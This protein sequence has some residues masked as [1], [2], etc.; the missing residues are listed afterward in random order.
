MPPSELEELVDAE[1]RLDQRLAEA[2]RVAAAA[3]DAAHRRV[4]EAATTLAHEI[5][6]DRDRID[7]EIDTATEAVLAAIAARADAEVA[8]FESVRDVVVDALARALAAR[9]AEV[10]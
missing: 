8:R 9:L 2:R 3:R 5:A 4:A 1:A 10:A 7:A 6:R